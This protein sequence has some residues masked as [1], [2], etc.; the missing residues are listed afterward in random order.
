MLG[1]HMT[2]RTIHQVQK[3]KRIKK[4]DE[5]KK[6]ASN[7][8]RRKSRMV[9]VRT[10]TKGTWIQSFLDQNKMKPTSWTVSGGLIETSPGIRITGTGSTA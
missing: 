7:N 10:S 5:K 3:I 1:R 9:T 4:K 2:S 6:R 8:K